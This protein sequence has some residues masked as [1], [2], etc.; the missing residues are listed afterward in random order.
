MNRKTPSKKAAQIAE[1]AKKAGGMF[2]FATRDPA[3]CDAENVSAVLSKFKYAQHAC[4]D[5]GHAFSAVPAS[6]LQYHCSSCGS[7]TTKAEATTAKLEI[8]SDNNL[9]LVT[10]GSC[11]THNI[12]PGAVVASV[13]QLNC[14]ACG[15]EMNY[16]TT[17]TTAASDTVKADADEMPMNDYEST[18]LD[19]MDLVDI[20]DDDDVAEDDSGDEL[21]DEESSTETAAPPSDGNPPDALED[22]GMK[23]DPAPE[24][25]SNTEQRHNAVEN[26]TQDGG[27]DIEV[28]MMD[29]VTERPT[30]NVSPD[31]IPTPPQIAFVYL[32]QTMNVAVG[33][34]IVASL[35]PEL[36]G[37]NAELM[38]QKNFQLAVKHSID[39]LGLKEAL[40]HYKFEPVKVKI[41]ASAEIAKLVKTSVETEQ[42]KVTANIKSVA[43][44][45]AQA[46]D[47]AAAG[48]AQNFWK[49]RQDPVKA[50]LVTELVA[51][52]MKHGSAE[53]LVNRVYAAH[54]AA[55]MREVIALAREVAAKPVEARNGLAEA[56]NLSEY[57][58]FTMVKAD[59]K[60]GDPEAGE[61][62]EDDDNT[63]EAI[64]AAIAT[65]VQH[66]ESANKSVTGSYKT[67]ELAVLLGN[68]SFSS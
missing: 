28:N 45:F 50:A 35:T 41:K 20:E 62:D 47:I 13:S 27:L 1:T 57:V 56:L 10:C 21:F 59:A 14:S 25:D 63:E 68:G 48:F 8:P 26:M 52:G 38:F 60:D 3:L 19:D 49:N 37:D 51:A 31:N 4:T 9:A 11:S 5:C 23:G 67:Q 16:K 2:V 6:G 22:T 42:S 39:T 30:P 34:T 46:T 58:P 15:H 53:R 54:G 18:D 12:F 33:N 36:A 66:V 65:P 64:V 44:D 29:V 7:P 32:G 24:S 40:A 17:S 55:Q 61:E 43:D